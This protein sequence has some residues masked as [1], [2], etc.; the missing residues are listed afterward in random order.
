M[1]IDEKIK[2]IKLLKEIQDGLSEEKRSIDE[3]LKS[4]AQE[5]EVLAHELLDEMKSNGID[6]VNT[7]DGSLVAMVSKNTSIGY[8]NDDAL[9]G[10]LSEN[11]LSEFLK[12]TVAIKKRELSAEIKK[13]DALREALAEYTSPKVTEYVVVTS[14]EKHA[15]MLE[16]ISD[17]KSRQ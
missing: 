3:K 6:T 2:R 13:N 11:G 17:S 8:Q 7:E 12:T 4:A 5:Y 15:R 9:I 1:T 14:P 10:Y 16:H